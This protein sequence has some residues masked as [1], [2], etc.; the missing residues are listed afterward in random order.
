MLVSVARSS[1]VARN[2]GWLSR[3]KK[4]NMCSC[5]L[6]FFSFES[7]EMLTLNFPILDILRALV[8]KPQILLLDEATS[9]LDSESES[10]VQEALDRLMASK[11]H[12]TIVIAHR[13][14]TIRDVDRIFYIANGK[15]KEHGSHDEL[16]EKPKGLYKRLVDTQ[17]RGATID[18]NLLKKRGK[19]DKDEEEE[20]TEET[21]FEAQ[22]EEKEKE[23][24]S[25]ARARKMAAP[26]ASYMLVGAVGSIIAGGVFPCW[27]IMFAETI[28]LLFR[29][30]YNCDTDEDAAELGF[31]TCDDYFDF[32][33]DD[34][35][36]TSFELAVY[37]VIVAV[38][39]V[40][41]NMLLFW[42]FG[43]A[44]ERLNK[45]VRDSAFASLVRQEVAFFDQR[46]VGT[47]TSQLE[48]D[49]A[50]IH[51]FSGEPIRSFLVATSSIITGVLISFIF[52]WP[53]ALLSL[54]TIPFM[55]FATEV[56][57]RTMLG[58]DESAN[59]QDELNSPGG[60]V[61]ETLIN[62][63]TV[64]AL[65]L[66][67]TRFDD[68]QAALKD[69]N[70]N[71]VFNGF[72]TGFTSGMSMFIQQW[73]N[74]LQLWWGGWLLFNYPDTFS[75]NDFLISMFALLFSLFGLGAA[76]QGVSDRKETEKSAGRVFYL[77]D[78]ESEIDPLNDEGKKLN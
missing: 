37:W 74:A 13:L 65:T 69:E 48:D 46:S 2:N 76:F 25:L 66:E 3:G 22:L 21:D 61:V 7:K 73:V 57:M 71:Y 18:A 36:T 19:E 64:S 67:K 60:I 68:Y 15:V 10:I 39:C 5:S 42:G 6:M 28:N 78:R 62:I 75:F 1:Q 38:G 54:A 16:M 14:S 43:M 52:M 30:V 77:L 45:R 59:T 44:S 56:E 49:A 55:G 31:D 50:R 58:E 70:S 27:G 24:F 40:V 72:K 12:T 9:A 8:K 34:M 63:R 53:F 23:A 20:E 51:T 17:R 32:V 33:A 35:R 11:D 41:G 29:R 4:E 47:I 26:D